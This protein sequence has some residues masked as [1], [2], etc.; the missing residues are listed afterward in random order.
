M[1]SVIALHCR[2]WI[3]SHHRVQNYYAPCLGA[4][5]FVCIVLDPSTG[6]ERKR[7]SREAAMAN[8]AP[9]RSHSR[10]YS[11]YSNKKHHRRRSPSGYC[12]RNPCIIF[13]I[14]FAALGTLRF[15]VPARSRK[16]AADLLRKRR[17]HRAAHKRRDFLASTIVKNIASAG[18][19]STAASTAAAAGNTMISYKL[20]KESRDANKRAFQKYGAVQQEDDQPISVQTWAEMVSQAADASDSVISGLNHAIRSAPFSAVFF[21]TPPVVNMTASSQQFEFV[22]M[23]AP[24]L[25]A[26]ATDRPD[27]SAFAQQ[28]ERA[29]ISHNKDGDTIMDD[30]S[31]VVVA[32]D[33][34]RGDA[35]LI[36]PQPIAENH[37]C[38]AHLASFVRQAPGPQVAAVW[39]RA[40][41]E[42]LQR[43]A[44]QQAQQQAPIW[45]STSGMGVYWLHF[46]LDSVPKYY[47]Y[48]PYKKLRASAL[49]A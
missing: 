5:C 7:L 44:A 19:N 14:S 18:S 36:A 20:L 46:R 2:R 30:D 1:R 42:Y 3:D 28:F 37:K 35:R 22:L 34:L 4:S 48:E 12:W 13:L 47:T 15:R 24:D 38:Y 41:H 16:V 11:Y 39:R 25:Q 27:R 21:E 49:Q 10:Y 45:F 32:F 40:A 26:V 29:K 43:L 31:D 6:R 9:H 23:D 33:S 8:G 17:E